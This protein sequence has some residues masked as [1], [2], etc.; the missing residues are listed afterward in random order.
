MK[1]IFCY[2]AMALLAGAMATAC[3]DDD[4]K[5]DIVDPPEP[6]GIPGVVV[7][8]ML[9]GSVKAGVADMIEIIGSGF[10]PNR[11]WV[12]I[13]YEKGGQIAYERIT[14]DVLTIKSGRITFGV[15]ITASYLGETFKVYLDR[16]GE[17][18]ELTNDLTFTM[19]TVADGYIPD[20]DFPRDARQ[21]R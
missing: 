4:K 8:N 11:D 7:D 1:R 17:K 18:M 20:P 21:S 9:S 13:G 5:S 19:P 12:F 14:T 10:D 6:V 16:D 15:P 3:G 2:F